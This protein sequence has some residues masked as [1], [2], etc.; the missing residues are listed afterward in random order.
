MGKTHE[1]VSRRLD[2]PCSRSG[3]GLLRDGKS[4]LRE[5]KSEQTRQQSQ[6]GCPGVCCELINGLPHFCGRPNRFFA[7]S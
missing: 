1:A 4:D 7:N 2:D 3:G 5:M 6:A